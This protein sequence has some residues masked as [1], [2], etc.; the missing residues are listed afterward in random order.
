[1]VFLEAAACGL[2]VVAGAAGGTAGAVVHGS[3]GLRVDGTS[4]PAIAEA[5]IRLTKDRDLARRLGAK[6]AERAR[7]EFSWSAVADRT[8]AAVNR[9]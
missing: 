9:A 8:L 2:A 6:G 5:L 4:L 7:A 1:M 3:T